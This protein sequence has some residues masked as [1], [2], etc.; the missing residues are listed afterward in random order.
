M[1]E[2]LFDFMP[3]WQYL[4]KNYGLVTPTSLSRDASASKKHKDEKTNRPKK[5]QN[6]K[7]VDNDNDDNFN[8]D[9][10]Y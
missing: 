3:W 8:V 9:E 1:Y 7:V 5:G 2:G 6:Q 4:K 10:N